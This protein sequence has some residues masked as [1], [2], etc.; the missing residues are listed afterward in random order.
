MPLIDMLVS[1]RYNI[2]IKQ[3]DGKEI[4]SSV[5]ANMLDSDIVVCVFELQSRFDIHFLTNTVWKG[6]NA[7]IAQ[8]KQ[9]FK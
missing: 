6:L 9:W 8:P 1:T 7:I 2:S 4:P 3:C 5:V